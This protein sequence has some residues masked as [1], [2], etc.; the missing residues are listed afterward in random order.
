[1][2]GRP[3]SLRLRLLFALVGTSM[4]VFAAVDVATISAIR[5]FLLHR[6]DNSVNRVHTVAQRYLE[7]R[8]V[9]RLPPT[10]TP[11]RYYV[12]LAKAD[13]SLTPLLPDASTSGN[14]PTLPAKLTRVSSA[15]RTAP[16]R[17][18]GPPYR[19][20]VTPFSGRYLVVGVS[21]EDYDA[22]VGRLTLDIVL[23]SAAAFVVLAGA[24]WA[25]TR[26]GLRPLERIADRADTITG[27]ELS[28]RIAV[29][30]A[31]SEV[32]RVSTAL[33]AMLD[34]I[35]GSV[36]E[37][38]A[39]QQSI[40]Q[41]MADASHEL[42]TPL[43]TVRAYAEL[44][45]QGALRD[46]IAVDE[47]M[48]RIHGEAARM[49]ELVD[50]LLCL[51]RSDAAVAPE[52]VRVDLA[53]VL[54]DAVADARAVEPARQIAV[55][56]E[57]APVDGDPAQLQMVIGNLL[58]N[59]RVHGGPE[60][61]VT[62]TLRRRGDRCVL[63]VTDTGPGVSPDALPH[64]FER[65]FRTDRGSRGSGLGLAIVAAIVEAHGG[66][67]GAAAAAPSGL[68]ITVELPAAG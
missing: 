14:P 38:D 17:S 15:P 60:A 67:V 9:D 37:R 10:F 63:V 35:E 53:A 13:G 18:G 61:R 27:G 4:A 48:A 26:R 6:V 20:V 30:A 21:L 57:P 45:Q 65:F 56:A 2:T 66:R 19:I 43:T 58:A 59:V 62:A 33:D 51:A 47:A 24:G 11:G 52:R 46:R 64:L 32:G 3:R 8:V 5:S 68:Q 49:S 29:R 36:Q 41:F 16:A 44:Y 31:T 34:R 28:Q 54:D 7:G 39:A 25:L 22:T 23:A 1:M 40:R 12:G 50:Q 55:D 42:R